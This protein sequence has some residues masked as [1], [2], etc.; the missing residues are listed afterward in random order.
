MHQAVYQEHGAV[1]AEAGLGLTL[2]H[3]GDYAEARCRLQDAVERARSVTHRRRLAEALIGLG[4]VEI[5][6]G[7]QSA[8]RRCL[9]EAVAV[10]RDSKCREGLAAGLA[11]LARVER[12]AGDAADALTYACEAVRVAQESTLPV[13]EMWG[14]MEAGLALLAQGELVAALEH[15]ERA[16]ALVPQA[17]EGWVGTE[18]VHRAHARVL[19]ALGRVDEADEQ[20]R[21][22]EAI[23]EA[24]AGHIPD[25][26]LRQRFLQSW[27]RA[28][29]VGSTI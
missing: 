15:T 7:Q 20:T 26:E 3:L 27:R 16:V 24:K 6:A 18:Q 25:P 4:L 23:V 12:Q 19:R 28:S 21:L 5:A 17:H 22:A 9:T 2:Y 10:A 8:A 1:A 13:C 11:A 14:E 29:V